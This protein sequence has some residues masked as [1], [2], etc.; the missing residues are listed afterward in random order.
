MKD[1]GNIVL[2]RIFNI[3]SCWKIICFVEIVE[4]K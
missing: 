4:K 1:D 2:V 3:G